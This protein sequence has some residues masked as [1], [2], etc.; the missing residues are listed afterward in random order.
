MNLHEQEPQPSLCYIKRK[1]SNGSGAINFR[2]DCNKWRVRVTVN[3]KRQTIGTFSD[4]SDAEKCL[5]AYIESLPTPKIDEDIER[6][7]REIES[8]GKS[9]CIHLTQGQIA[10]IDAADFP[11]VSQLK[12]QASWSENTRSYYAVAAYHDSSKR[13]RQRHILMARLIMGVVD[14]K[15]IWVDHESHDTLDNRQ[16]NLRFATKKENARNR[17]IRRTQGLKWTTFKK[18]E[19]KWL[20]QITADGV[21]RCLGLY[22]TA[23]EA[24]EVAKAEA[25]KIHAKFACFET[26]IEDPKAADELHGEFANY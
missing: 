23:E 3:E 20:S 2:P 7:I 8:D 16:S 11:L 26:I 24:H 25:I 12:W 4:K 13:G 15:S 1:S 17:R 18:K 5:S 14:D 22:D 21:L 10:I 19:G 9:R 6:R